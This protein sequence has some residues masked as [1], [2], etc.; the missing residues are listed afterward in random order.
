MGSIKKVRVGPWNGVR[1]CGL[2][3]LPNLVFKIIYT[4]NEKEFFYSSELENNAVLTRFT[5][6]QSGLLER[7]ILNERSTEWAVKYT[8]PSEL[9]DNYGQCGAN[10]VCRMNKSPMCECLKG[11]MP[12]S[13]EE[14]AML[15][16]SSGCIRRTP[17]DCHSG[18][19]GGGS[20]CLMWFGDLID[21]R[22]F[23]AGDG[24][25]DIYIYIR[26]PAWELDMK[27][28]L[29]IILVV[30]TILGMLILGFIFWAL[31]LLD[32]CLE[33]SCVESQVVRCIQVGLLCVQRFPEDRPAMSSVVFMLANEGATLPQPKQP[34]FFIERSSFETAGIPRK[35]EFHTE[36][37]V[38]TSMLEGR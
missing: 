5:L 32:T 33:N 12:R 25:E 26:L 22:E 37:S 15:N 27:K 23:I 14:L 28:R 21:I 11:F 13:Q 24:E 30:S 35:D 38:T 1:F 6:N 18:E 34:G 29:V 2:H 20:D 7:L 4:Y 9:C 36:N 17:L 8:R 16:W 19:G 10:A 31:E 3:N